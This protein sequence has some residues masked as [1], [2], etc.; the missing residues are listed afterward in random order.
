[1]TQMAMF[2]DRGV[3]TLEAAKAAAN[4]G[5]DRVLS[6]AEEISDQWGRTAYLFLVKFARSHAQFIAGD[7]I[8]ASKA[9]IDQ[10]HD[11]RAWGRIFRRAVK[12]GFIKHVEYVP[13]PHRHCSP[14]SLYQSGIH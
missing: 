2:D 13:A 11:N 12:V 5:M 14:V 4:E 3:P 8:A 9:E 1:M 7:V 10:P 6:H